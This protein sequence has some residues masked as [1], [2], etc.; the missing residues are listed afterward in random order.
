MVFWEDTSFFTLA[1]A[2]CNGSIYS[3]NE[4]EG[5]LAPWLEQLQVHDFEVVHRK[6]HG[7]LNEDALSH[8]CVYH[9]MGCTCTDRD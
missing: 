7:H 9:L 8:V 3:M 2:R 5:K 4:P 1:T 6:G